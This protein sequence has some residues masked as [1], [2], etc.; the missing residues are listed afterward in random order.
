MVLTFYIH[1]IL[2]K[3]YGFLCILIIKISL[4]C[5]NDGIDYSKLKKN[6]ALW[7]LKISNEFQEKSK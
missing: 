1:T 2:S 3:S 6:V 5:E 4:G 7:P